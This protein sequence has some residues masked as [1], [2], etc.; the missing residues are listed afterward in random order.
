MANQAL[1]KTNYFAIGMYIKKTL[2]NIY[3][4]IFVEKLSANIWNF[5]GL[6]LDAQ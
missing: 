5:T 1:V 2:I 6:L 3:H 4:N